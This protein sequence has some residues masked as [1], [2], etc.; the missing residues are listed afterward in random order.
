MILT[1]GEK[2]TGVVINALNIQSGVVSGDLK[3]TLDSEI[4]LDLTARLSTRLALLKKNLQGIL[5]RFLSRR[6]SAPL[7]C[8]YQGKF[9]PIS[10]GKGKS[11]T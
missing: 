1:L 2:T 5:A 4:A 10:Y 11:H 8:D 3:G 6:G 7:G 9:E